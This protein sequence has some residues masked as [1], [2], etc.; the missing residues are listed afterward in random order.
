MAKQHEAP[1][2]LAEALGIPYRLSIGKSQGRGKPVKE[3]Y[4]IGDF[5]TQDEIELQR[6]LPTNK[7]R[8]KE[9]GGDRFLVKSVTS[10]E[11]DKLIDTAEF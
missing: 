10:P 6:S 7:A 8:V 2:S 5:K 3:L 11:F 9:L 1:L 4:V